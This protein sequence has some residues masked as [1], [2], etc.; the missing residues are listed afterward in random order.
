M[1][2]FA[3]AATTNFTVTVTTPEHGTITN[4]VS[5]T[6]ITSDPVVSN[7]DG[8]SASGQVLTLILGV[9]VTGYVYLDAN[10]NGFKDNGETGTSLGLYAKIF[11]TT[12]ASGPALQAA[13]VDGPSGAYT[14]TN[15]Y[16]GLYLMIIDNNDLLT[17]IT[18]TPPNGWTGTEMPAQT[19]TNVAVAFVNVPN[20]NFG[21]IHSVGLSGR[22]FKDIGSG[23]GTANDGIMNGPETGLAGVTVRLTDNTGATVYDSALTDASGNYTLLIPN[24]VA[25]GATLKVTETNLPVHLSTGGSPGDT[26]GNYDRTSD[27]VMFTYALGASYSGVNFGDVPDNSFVN[28]G[29]LAGLPGSFVVYPH[30]FVAGSGGSL[31]FSVANTATPSITG[32]SQVLYRDANGNGAL[33]AG[34]AVIT[35]AITVNAGEKVCILVKEFIPANAPFNAQDQLT[36]TAAFTWTSASPALSTNSTHTDLTTVGQPTTAGLTLLK[37]VDKETALP[38]EVLSY[39]LTYENKSSSALTNIF[40]FDQTPAFTT[41]T[42]AGHGS[43]PNS[44][45]GITV[46]APSVGASGAIKWTLTGSLAP[47]SSGTVTFSV[48]VAQ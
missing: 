44:I 28:D 46:N 9:N 21:L 5:S 27:T 18:P 11:A 42:S 3:S 33:D 2:N 35:G 31:N 22:V 48:T 36:V 45:T 34:E 32:W 20:Q 19:R 25:N 47:A 41:F 39:T 38:G 30:T 43:L 8:S 16:R 24:A 6:S 12:N 7:N 40:I 29:Q 10:K 15:V 13:A 4:I 37:I 23:G 1:T 26:G 14:L 17:D